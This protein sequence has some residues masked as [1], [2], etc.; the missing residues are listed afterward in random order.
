MEFPNPAKPK[1]IDHGDADGGFNFP[2]SAGFIWQ[3]RVSSPSCFRLLGRGFSFPDSASFIWQALYPAGTLF[4]ARS[5]GG[6]VR[7]PASCSVWSTIVAFRFHPESWD[8]RHCDRGAAA[9]PWFA[10]VTWVV[11]PAAGDGGAL[12]AAQGAEGDGRHQPRGD[13]ALYL[14]P[15]CRHSTSISDA[16]DRHTRWRRTRSLPCIFKQLQHNPASESV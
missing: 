15:P 13:G 4:C 7:M 16:E 5:S 3:A 9:S 11:V 8:A 10:P 6:G 14:F 2:G 12:G 1:E